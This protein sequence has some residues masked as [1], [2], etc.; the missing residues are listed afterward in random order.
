MQLTGGSNFISTSRRIAKYQEVI[1]TH[2]FYLGIELSSWLL[3]NGLKIRVEFI[4]VQDSYSEVDNNYF[5]HGICAERLVDSNVLKDGQ[6]A[7][8]TVTGKGG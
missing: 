2:M 3:M 7:F 1:L 8:L 5:W 4:N 6:G